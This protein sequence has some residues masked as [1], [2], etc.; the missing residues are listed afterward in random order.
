MSTDTSP[1]RATADADSPAIT[2]ATL[3]LPLFSVGENETAVFRLVEANPKAPTPL[4][5]VLQVFDEKGEVL[6]QQK[7]RVAWNQPALLTFKP[8]LPV[9]ARGAAQ[10]ILAPGSVS[11]PRQTQDRINS[12]ALSEE[13][14]RPKTGSTVGVPVGG[15]GDQ[16]VTNE[17]PQPP[18]EPVRIYAVGPYAPIASTE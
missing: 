5:V 2:K 6:V 14:F 10:L 3:S 8:K 15:R 1:L 18:V 13:I 17:A 9:V 4:D 16:V 7:A 12:L 11:D